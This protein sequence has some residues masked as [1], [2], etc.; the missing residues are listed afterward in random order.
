MSVR[1]APTTI[2]FHDFLTRI[3]P[4]AVILGP[5]IYLFTVNWPTLSE[6]TTAVLITVVLASFLLGEGVELLR[7][8]AFRVPWPL[9]RYLFETTG[10]DKHKLT[11]LQ[12]SL[13]RSSRIGPSTDTVVKVLYGRFPHLRRFIDWFP[14]Q[15]TDTL[16]ER[17][18]FNFKQSMEQQWGIAF[19]RTSAADV[20]DLL[21]LEL[22]ATMGR[23]ARRYRS[24]H[25]F[26][27]NIRISSI[28]G[29]ILY[30]LV[31]LEEP[32]NT[33]FLYAFSL[34]AIIAAYSLS[35]SIMFERVST[36]YLETLFKEYYIKYAEDSGESKHGE[37]SQPAS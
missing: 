7:S 14:T 20:Y 34:S 28:A 1:V 8:S 37:V 17:F 32:S 19:E 4:G 22:E 18:D 36:R 25:A 3:L 6:N 16:S 31:Y 11:K 27:S 24:L 26:T 13:L 29:V 30:G 5:G 15:E 12:Y 35:F 2:S 9:R 33:G 10:Q 23:D 21:V